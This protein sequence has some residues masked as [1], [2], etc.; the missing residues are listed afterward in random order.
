MVRSIAAAE[1]VHPSGVSVRYLRDTLDRWIR[2]DRACGRFDEL[3][4]VARVTNPRTDA[5][6]LDMA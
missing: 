4:P 5:V 2:R 1:H 3:V 6:V